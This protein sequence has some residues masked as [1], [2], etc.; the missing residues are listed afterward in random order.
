MVREPRETSGTK[1]S[2]H[3]LP[4]GGADLGGGVRDRVGGAGDV[5][6]VAAGVEDLGDL[7]EV[8]AG[9]PQLDAGGF[10]AVEGVILVEV[11][12]AV[13]CQAPGLV[14][15]RLAGFLQ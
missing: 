6:G 14:E 10:E 2:A 11:R 4:G 5:E 15:S 9:A 13:E 3:Q 1:A 8:G 7:V 12:A